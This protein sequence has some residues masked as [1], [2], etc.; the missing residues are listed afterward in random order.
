MRR[1][2]ICFLD[3]TK[4]S[5]KPRLWQKTAVEHD[6]SVLGGAEQS[7]VLP[8]DFILPSDSSTQ[9]PLSV[10]FESLD[11]FATADSVHS[12]EEDLAS[13]MSND[14]DVPKIQTYS[15]LMRFSTLAEGEDKK[16]VNVSLTYDVFFVTAHPCIPS[17]HAEIL[18]T[19]TSPAFRALEQTSSS[20]S[21]LHA[22]KFLG[23]SSSFTPDVSLVCIELI[24]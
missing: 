20:F 21:S 24:R 5:S 7:T 9:P 8:G 3:S 15:T 18:K 17:A 2:L 22:H 23:K 11:L 10:T 1:S 16:E 13:P 4:K 12:K 19:P 6:S 14:S